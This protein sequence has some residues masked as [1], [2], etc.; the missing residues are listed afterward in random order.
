ML[1]RLTTIPTATAMQQEQLSHTMLPFPSKINSTP[2]ISDQFLYSGKQKRQKMVP[3]LF[4]STNF[5]FLYETSIAL[6]AAL[7]ATRKKN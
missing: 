6:L 2:K 5:R 7:T 3:F 1:T 4:K